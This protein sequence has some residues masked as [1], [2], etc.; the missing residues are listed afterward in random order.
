[1]SMEIE[2]LSQKIKSRLAKTPLF[3]A[4]IV[5]EFANYRYRE[6]LLAW[7]E[8]RTENSLARDQQGRYL[9]R[10]SR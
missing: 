8:I 5:N 10:T 9:I 1:M 6:I 2:T 4:E 7:S 3:F